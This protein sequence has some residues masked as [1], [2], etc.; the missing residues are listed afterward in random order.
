M[1]VCVDFD[2]CSRERTSVTAVTTRIP[3]EGVKATSAN[4]LYHVHREL[5]NWLYKEFPVKNL[6]ESSILMGFEILDVK[7]GITFPS[8]LNM[9]WWPRGLQL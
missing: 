2:S 7:T 3:V 5:G 1:K 6:P 8:S 4:L 9:S